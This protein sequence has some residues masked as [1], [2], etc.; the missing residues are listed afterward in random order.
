MSGMHSHSTDE[1]NIQ[2]MFIEMLTFSQKE[3]LT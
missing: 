3:I 2:N 1:S